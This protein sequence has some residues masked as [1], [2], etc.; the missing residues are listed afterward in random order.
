[1][2][3]APPQD[4]TAPIP[5]GLY[6]IRAASRLS[7]LSPDLIRIWQRRYGVV[8][9][10][11][12][13]GHARRYSAAEVR[14]LAMLRELTQRGHAIGDL[15]RLPDDRLQSLLQ[16]KSL[17]ETPVQSPPLDQ[18]RLLEGVVRD[19]LQAIARLDVRQAQQIL[20]RAAT[21]LP[22]EV[23]VLRV[24]IPVL[25]EVGDRWARNELGVAH[26]HVVSGQMKGFLTDLL[27]LAPAPPPGAPR[28][29]AATPSGHL[30]EFGVLLAAWLAAV[31]GWD[32][33]WAGPDLPSSDLLQA[34]ET[35]QAELVVLSVIREPPPAELQRLAADLRGLSRHVRL[36]VG[37][38]EGHPLKD[39][40]PGV[41]I[42]HG[43][44]EMRSALATLRRLHDAPDDTH[45]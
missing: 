8:E 32:V 28:L 36:W 13:A 1:M 2:S 15:A 38:P 23:F 30:H 22:P 45:A 10:A 27:R 41:R 12:T 40:M 17:L 11:R 39:R 9:P 33:T 18:D 16:G 25:R 7:G 44:E 5:E 43:I 14:R 42:F 20:A 19:Y 35:L 31:D 24:A 37:M 34:A 21:L 6:P 26:E 29:L 3:D 4:A